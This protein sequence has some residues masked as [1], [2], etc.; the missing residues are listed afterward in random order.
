MLFLLQTHTFLGCWEPGSYVNSDGNVKL[1]DVVERSVE[2]RQKAE[3][4]RMELV[5]WLRGVVERCVEGDRDDCEREEK[6]TR[7]K[8]RA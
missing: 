7:E 3:E 4:K 8:R 5:R 6:M 2:G 1:R